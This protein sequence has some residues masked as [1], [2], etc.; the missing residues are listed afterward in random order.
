[1]RIRWAPLAALLLLPIALSGCEQIK[2]ALLNQVSSSELEGHLAEW[3]KDHD[4]EAKEI[5][6]PDG[7]KIEVGNTFE[8]TC[9]VHGTEI[10]VTVRVTDSAG[11]LEWEPKYLTITRENVEEEIASKP[12][13]A[14][15]HLDID[16]HDPVW[17]SIPDSEWDCEV[18]DPDDGGKQFKA[19]VKF[20]DGE[21]TH[22]MTVK[23]V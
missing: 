9:Q 5:H 8:C 17:V 19:T 13:F 23:E 11:S 10:P 4:L 16:C 21:G 3:L 1:M 18:T 6:C 2:A 7:Q 15:H 22:E 14:G 20:L 12:E